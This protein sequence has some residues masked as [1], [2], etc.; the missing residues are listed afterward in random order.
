MTV[1]SA[2]FYTIH[3]KKGDGA[4]PN[5]DPAVAT[6]RS[7]SFIFDFNKING[8]IIEIFTFFGQNC[9]E[10][11]T[12]HP[13]VSFSHTQNAFRFQDEHRVIFSRGEQ[14]TIRF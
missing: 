14:S 9:A 1:L 8:I 13:S 2:V 4:Q 11:K 7:S 5:S 6:L 10:M 12:F 3:T